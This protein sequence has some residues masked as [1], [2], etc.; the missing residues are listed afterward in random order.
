VPTR[1]SLLGFGYRYLTSAGST[2]FLWDRLDERHEVHLRYQVGGP[3]AFEME[4]R[5]ELGPLRLIDTTFAVVRNLDCMQIGFAYHTHQHSFEMIFNLLPSLLSR[6]A[7]PPSTATS[8]GF[9]PEL[10]SDIPHF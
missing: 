9:T 3:W 10:M 7:R 4:P 8:E 2:P 5:T 6:T 1:T